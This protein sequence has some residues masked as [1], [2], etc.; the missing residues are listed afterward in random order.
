MQPLCYSAGTADGRGWFG[1]GSPET[2]QQVCPHPIVQPL[3]LPLLT[4]HTQARA[5][6]Y[7]HFSLCVRLLVDL[8]NNT[9]I[10]KFAKVG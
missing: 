2:S 6:V 1:C 8:R 7:N 10:L 5:Y 9:A 3:A 4:A